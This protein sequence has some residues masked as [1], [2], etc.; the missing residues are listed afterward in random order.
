[1]RVGDDQELLVSDGE[2]LPVDGA[3]HKQEVTTRGA[4]HKQEVT[5]RGANPTSVTSVASLKVIIK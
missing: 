1:M 4:G 5:T 3:A 2:E